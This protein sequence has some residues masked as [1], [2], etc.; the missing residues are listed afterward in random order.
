[1][2]RYPEFSP[3]AF[4]IGPLQVHWYGLMYLFGFMACWLLGN[5]RAKRSDNIMTRER[6]ADCIFYAALGVILGGR[7]GYVLFYNLPF[8]WHHPLMIF[9]I[10]DGGMSFHGGLMGVI[11]VS[12]LLSRHF[13]CSIFDITDF[14]APMVPIGLAAG[15]LGNFING[16]L[17]GRV[18]T[19]P[20]GMVFPTGG[21]LPRYPSQLIECFL[22]GLVLF[23]WLWWLSRKPRRRMFISASFLMGYG[24]AR[25]VAECFRQP[26]PQIGFLAF[27][28]LTEGQL[29]SLPMILLG[30]ALLLWLAK[31]QGRVTE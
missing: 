2:L 24:C 30:V 22:E 7:L 5:W 12:W 10:W 4:S 26:D 21:P 17:W 23:V 20:I 9:A 11:V 8:Y 16:E 18:T 28:W 3:I 29:L 31:K 13:A 27:G 25:F 6:V 15:R 19:S 1:M 14:F